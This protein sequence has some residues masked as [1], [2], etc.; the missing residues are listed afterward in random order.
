[1]GKVTLSHG[2]KQ[3]LADDPC[4]PIVHAVEQVQGQ[5]HYRR[6]WRVLRRMKRR[7]YEL[8]YV[9]ATEAKNPCER[10]LA[11]QLLGFKLPREEPDPKLSRI[12]ENGTYMHLRFSN[13]FMSLPDPFEVKI[14]VLLRRWPLVGEA[15]AII[16]HP[17]IDWQVIE[18]KSINDNGFKQL[19][20]GAQ[21]SH[22]LQVNT[23]Q[24]LFVEE[25][26]GQ[27]WY[28]NKNN[29]EIKTFV[30]DYDP[31][32]FDLLFQRVEEIAD[33]VIAGNLPD[34]CGECELDEFVGNL[35]GVEDRM[36]KLS[37]VREASRV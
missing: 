12:F 36:A 17:E 24:G 11:A 9:H 13:Y 16:Y 29:Q 25:S 14:A 15:D 21:D 19:R 8:G 6:L 30:H 22:A 35:R 34:A 26:G 31:T 7:K 3:L 33:E 32:E 18:L 28:E 20:S 27:I 4:S 37:E 2:M 10:V 5:A 1:M 23:Y